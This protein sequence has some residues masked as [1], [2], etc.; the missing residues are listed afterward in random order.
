M[1]DDW[2]ERGLVAEAAKQRQMEQLNFRQAKLDFDGVDPD[3]GMHLLSLHWNRQHHSFLITYRPAFMR[4]MACNGP[5]FSKLLLNAIYF[6]AAKFS[7][8]LEVRKDPND[9]RTAGWRYRER[10]RELLGGALDHSDITTIQALLVMT[11]SLFA[12]GDERSAAWLY[13]GLAFRMLIDM[14]M[15][16]DLTSTHRFSDED[17]EIRRRVFWGAFVVDKIQSLYQ[18]RP[19]SLKDTDALVPIKFLDTYEELE[20]WQP[21]AYTTSAPDYPGMPA[22]SISTFTCLCK[23]S[24][25]MS[26]ILS[27]IYTERSS[28][29]RP[30]ELAS[31]LD[32]LQ[33]RLD[34]WKAT[35][36][37]HLRFD[38]GKARSVAFPPPHVSSLHAMHN[39]L[40]ILLHRPFVADGHLYSTSPSISVDSF[41]KCAS[42]ASNT[43]NL[44]RAYH[45]AFS[46][47]RAPYLISYATYV[48]ATILTRIAAKRR[49]DSIAH[50]NLATC[51]AVFKENQETNSAVKKAANIV[52][53]LMKRLG[54]VID[55]ISLDA[56]EIDPPVKSSE[57]D[58]Q[59]NDRATDG[60]VSVQPS[61]GTETHNSL[62]S[63][64]VTGYSNTKSPGQPIQSPGSD[65]VDI[66][67]IIQSFLHENSTRGARL[68]DY[69]ANGTP[70]Q[71]SRAPW[72]PLHPCD[73]PATVTMDN[74]RHVGSQASLRPDIDVTNGA[75]RSETA[76]GTS[77]W[78][79]GWRPTNCEPTSLEDPLFG[80]NGSAT[81]FENAAIFSHTI[82]HG[83]GPMNKLPVL[84]RSNLPDMATELVT[85]T[86]RLKRHALPCVL[87]RAGTSKGI[88]LHQ[89]DLPMK[90]VDWAPH[91]VSA[92]GSRGNDPR[93]IDGVG[94]GTSTTSKVAVVRRSQRPD[95]DIDWTFV[96]VA[97]GKESVDFT[98]T[99]GNMTAGVAPFAIQEGLIKPQ[100]EQ[101]KMDVRIYNT[102]TDRIV[103]ET[104][105]LDSSGDYEED[106]NFIISGVKTP[107][108]EVKCRF[109]KPFG[110][111]TGKLFP[112]AD[113]QQQTLWVQPLM[114]GREP[115][116]V[117][118]TLI[119]S[120]NP[121]VL[122][123]TTSISATL[124]GT[125]PSDSDRNDL[126]ESIRRAGAVAMGLATDVEAAGRTRGTPKAA[127]VFPPTITQAGGS[128]KARPDIRIQ[129]YSMGL[130]HP[131]LQL[132][133]A[134][135][136]AVA[137][138]YPGT[139]VAGLSAM[140]SIMHGTLPPTPAQSPPPDYQKEEH[141]GLARD[142]LI[143]HSQGT[144]KVDVEMANG[145]EVASCAVSRTAR[146]LFEGK[147][148]YYIQED[149]L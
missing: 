21:F 51:L 19:V 132:T 110:S 120:A 28:N 60:D 40:V 118:V 145:G 146:R 13:S 71:L 1:P 2:V 81:G 66:D 26:D 3:L 78:Q 95:A 100:R 43:S 143:E 50:A 59:P 15:H 22:Y 85:K 76:S 138:S 149:E 83:F 125:N 82:C 92:L 30:A 88:F 74:A 33:L 67:G 90:E 140:G 116:D 114:P 77:Q 18:G 4:D 20:H 39:S 124:L 49:H 141:A 72:M 103:I 139:I 38:P 65:W 123:D 17:L 148:R 5:Y 79:Y 34:Q 54:V 131:S 104:V 119:D 63:G 89:K 32:E 35:L 70:T 112:S 86:R 121:F 87:M 117:R 107:G 94:G 68:L 58:P 53:G 23:L 25:I 147:V 9:V 12:L 24:L 84:A 97:V 8:R 10:V 14:G 46:I 57:R 45:R 80:L 136:I 105:T 126:V 62:T 7:P 47:R 64:N 137:L 75:H 69:E 115:F 37:E 42:A 99:C 133:G 29:Q 11:N 27:C 111:M 41:M 31:M 129:A 106:G 93:Q 73:I 127:L 6:G 55:N 102:N 56:L 96:Q 36:P 122:I 144:I 16:V 108:S 91:L 52:Q 130:P 44:L 98:G 142:V 135:T 134:V 109:V 128:I 113:Q 101:T 48:A 61:A